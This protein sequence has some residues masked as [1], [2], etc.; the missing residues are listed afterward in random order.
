ME[1][2]I[3]YASKQDRHPH[4]QWASV[5]LLIFTGLFTLA[6]LVL[7]VFVMSV[8]ELE[9]DYSFN[10]IN[11]IVSQ[12]CC[13]LPPVVIVC[14]IK[15]YDFLTVMRLR[16]GINFLQVLMLI[17]ISFGLIYVANGIN[18]IFL[19]IL[20]IFTG[21]APSG[22]DLPIETLPQMIFAAFLYGLLPAFC[23]EFFFR[24]LVM[25]AFERFSAFA[26]IVFSAAIFGIMH[27][28]LQQ[29]LFAAVI[30]VVLAIVVRQTDSLVPAMIIHFTNNFLAMVINFVQTSSGVVEEQVA[31][32]PMDTISSGITLVVSGLPILAILIPFIFYTKKRNLKKYGR[33]DPDELHKGYA[34]AIQAGN[35]RYTADGAA[36]PM[37]PAGRIP[38]FAYIALGVFLATQITNILTDFLVGIGVLGV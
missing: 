19:G 13:M 26:A 14:H 23:E 36:V 28:N 3:Q 34:A 32:T 10:M 37:N 2:E 15:K 9:K 20:E 4:L 1:R 18:S 12:L 21:Y 31:V 33:K 8:P 24:G 35:V 6:S 17:G 16:K 38:V 25:R 27:G 5:A 29:V 11:I 30:G 7:T 22:S